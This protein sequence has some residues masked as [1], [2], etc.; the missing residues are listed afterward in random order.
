MLSIFAI[1]LNSGNILSNSV[2]ENFHA[3]SS[4]ALTLN[5]FAEKVSAW[6]GKTP[7]LKYLPFEEWRNT[8]LE[9]DASLT[10][11][12]II[13]SPNCSIEKAKRLLNYQPRYSSLQA[14]HGSL[15]WLIDHQVIKI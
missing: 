7:K 15:M 6:F 4:Q 12:H 13:H 11:D 10:W 5:G 14:I 1:F 2:G 8:V 9:E 3:V